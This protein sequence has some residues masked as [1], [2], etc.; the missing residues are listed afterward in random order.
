[1]RAC[2]DNNE[3]AV[4]KLVENGADV[5]EVSWYCG[6]PRD[7]THY[8]QNALYYACRNGNEKIVKYL[9][10]HGADIN[11]STNYEETPLSIA[12]MYEYEK[13]VHYFLE[14]EPEIN[15]EAINI[16]CKKDNRTIINYL[17]EHKKI[18]PLRYACEMGNLTTVKYL[19]EQGANVNQEDRNGNTP[20]H[21]C[22]NKF[23]IVQY[24]VEQGANVNKM[25]K[26]HYIL[27]VKMNIME[28][29]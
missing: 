9:V 27:P 23:E 28:R 29:L 25:V 4:R 17:I 8:N 20:L 3:A 11:H 2:R 14:L 22:H 1:M 21:L 7:E 16:A 24:L 10:E 15:K 5:N 18:N 13:L 26:L 6:D 19:I 12:C